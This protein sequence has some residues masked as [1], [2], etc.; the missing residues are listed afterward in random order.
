MTGITIALRD[1]PSE[2]SSAK[3]ISPAGTILV[4]DD[5]ATTRKIME[6]ILKQRDF[7]VLLA[8]S[9]QEAIDI[10]Y[11]QCPDLILLDCSMPEMDGFDVCRRL[12]ADSDFDD[13]PIIF[14]T[15]KSSTEDK[16]RGFELGGSDFVTKPVDKV[17]L[18]ARINTHLEL[19]RGRRQLRK[20]TSMLE[21][22]VENQLERLSQVRNGQVSLLTDPSQFRQIKAAV[23]FLPALEAGGDFYDIVQLSDNDFGFLVADV[24][25]H[26]LG[27]AY[28][29]G[30]LKAL[31]VSFTNE[32]LSVVETFVMLNNA[33]LKFLDTGQ[34]A[35]AC[36]V[37]YSKANSEID[38]INAG[39][40]NP[41]LHLSDGS[42]YYTDL[43]GD[44]LGMFETITCGI[45][46]IK[47]NP[48][49]RLYMFTDGLTE[50][51]PN[52]AGKTGNRSFGARRL[53]EQVSLINQR[54]FSITRSVDYI[55]DELLNECS[56]TIE[57][58]VV[59]LGAEF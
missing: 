20:Q 44:V 39:H 29:T 14:L 43:V 2:K 26:D 54:Q 15:A 11:Y 3:S 49:D 4:V 5:D 19:A 28:L 32:T 51:Y 45:Q 9:G 35:T 22:L 50:G 57:D 53:Q 36:Y 10:V 17:A 52:A 6:T 34:Y 21:G 40:P 27:T 33:L 58:D 56:G 23:R 59:V 41:L 30:A 16:V 24:A 47:V 46:R 38:I 18:V 48:G 12:R 8:S 13:V 55:V 31:T 7:E 1:V 25:G 37:K 42:I